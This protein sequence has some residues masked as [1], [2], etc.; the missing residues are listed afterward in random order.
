MNF[1]HALAQP[2][3]QILLGA[4][5][6][7]LIPIWV[8][9]LRQ[10]RL[11]LSIETP[12]FEVDYPA[13]ERPAYTARYLRLRLFNK[14]LPK[15]M[16]WMLR[17]SA[18]QCHGTITFHHNDGQNVFGRAMSIRWSGSPQPIPLEGRIGNQVL[19]IVDPMRITLDSRMDVY[20]DKNEL[21]DV[22]ARFDNDAECY[23]WNNEAYFSDPRW[24][25]PDWRL[26]A[27]RY[28][29]RVTVNTSGKECVGVFSL[30]NDVPRKD[31]RLEEGTAEHR[32]A[33]KSHGY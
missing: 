2:A 23:G 1:Q 13:G 30:I 12:P 18:Q 10:P 9:Y 14:A 3:V 24:R 4:V 16:R 21:F 19:M 22:A 25:N 26:P 33:L 11:T 27:G 31:F 7:V 6:A 20:P 17:D 28:L 29:V 5:I 8:E 32:R 15:R